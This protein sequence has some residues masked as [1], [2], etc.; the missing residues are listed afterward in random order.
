[1]TVIG[2]LLI[3][4][5]CLGNTTFAPKIPIGTTG[6]LERIAKIKPPFLKGN[7]SPFYERVPSRYKMFCIF[8]LYDCPVN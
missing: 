6:N 8:N 4:I 7:N 3:F 2:S 1:M 5:E